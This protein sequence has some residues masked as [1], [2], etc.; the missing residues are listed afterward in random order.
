MKKLAFSICFSLFTSIMC[1]AQTMPIVEEGKEWIIHSQGTAP[2]C[3][4]DVH[5]TWIKGDTIVDGI[6]YKKYYQA[7][8]AED[9]RMNIYKIGYCRQE[10]DKFY[11]GKHLEFDMGLQKGDVFPY[12]KGTD[13]IVTDVGQTTL[14]DGIA[15]KYLSIGILHINEDTQEKTITEELDKWVEG[16]GSLRTGLYLDDYLSLGVKETLQSVSINGKAIY[17]KPLEEIDTV[18]IN[19][20]VNKAYFMPEAPTTEDEVT[21][22]VDLGHFRGSFLLKQQMEKIV[23]DTI[24]IGASYNCYT[25]MLGPNSIKKELSLGKLEEGQYKVLYRIEACN[26]NKPI[27]KEWTYTYDLKVAQS[28]NVTPD[29]PVIP[30]TPVDTTHYEPVDTGQVVPPVIPNEPTIYVPTIYEGDN[31]TEYPHSPVEGDA[32][33]EFTFTLEGDE[34]RIKGTLM[35]RG[36][37]K[38]YIHCQIIGDSVH[39]QRF[40]MDSENTDMILH[41]VDIR[42]PGFTENS[43]RVT[44]AEQYEVP[45]YKQYMVR[46]RMVTRRLTNIEAATTSPQCHLQTVGQTIRCTAPKAVKLEVYT[47]DAVKVGE[48]QFTNGTAT[49]TV[50]Q[51]PATYLYIVTYPDGRRESGKVRNTLN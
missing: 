24:Y 8:V 18:P 16:I 7:Q 46:S 25:P 36:Y 9:G 38:H 20:V 23:N 4:L 33:Q 12:L 14:E 17:Q 50:N 15:R 2:A 47:M 31:V 45:L 27:G 41:N 44:L 34:L 3:S 19:A 22:H 51:I 49:V 26:G 40:D 6:E 37:D 11:I 10:G 21:F 13:Y 29:K 42:I 32:K 28:G 39:L 48:A 5:K 30:D 1:L 35:A 43:Y